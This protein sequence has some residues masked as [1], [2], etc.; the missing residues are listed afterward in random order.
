VDESRGVVARLGALTAVDAFAGGLIVR[1][2]FAFWLAERFSFTAGEIGTLF[3]LASVTAA[4]SFP[5]GA[6]V[7]RRIGMVR[8]MVLTHI[9]SSVLLL[10]LAFL[11]GTAGGLAAATF[12]VRSFLSTMDV[13]I[14]QSYLMGIVTREER[15]GASGLMSVTR[16][17]AQTPSPLA[18]TG[19]LAV[20][21][22]AAPLA[23]AAGLQIVGD[24]T[25]YR[26]FADRP[27]EGEEA[28]RE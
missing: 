8:T 21:G 10:V 2:F 23:L 11:P 19:L 12:L 13:P 7:A 9:P 26:W 25:L 16:A 5:V 27:A 18:A 6:A 28:L 4:A 1:G 24:L 20:F 3:A 14:G 17:G 22:L 15:T